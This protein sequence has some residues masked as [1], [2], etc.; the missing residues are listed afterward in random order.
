MRRSKQSDAVRD[1]ASKR[2]VQSA[3]EAILESQLEKNFDRKSSQK[4]A[5]SRA[6]WKPD[7]LAREPTIDRAEKN[8][9]HTRRRTRTARLDAW[10]LHPAVGPISFLGLMSL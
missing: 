6:D 2:I 3:I 5:I 7:A 9:A 4:Q 8:S 10:L 1:T